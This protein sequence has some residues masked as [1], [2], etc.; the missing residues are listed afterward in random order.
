MFVL[1]LDS[2]MIIYI[3]FLSIVSLAIDNQIVSYAGKKGEDRECIT[4]KEKWGKPLPGRIKIN[5]DA[6]LVTDSNLFPNVDS[7]SAGDWYT[8]SAI[9]RDHI[10]DPICAVTMFV[11]AVSINCAE[12]RAIELGADL[13]IEL[14]YLNVILESDSLNAIR[15]VDPMK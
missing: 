8:V 6:S 4:V 1:L 9:A 12:L 10:G 7:T 5:V 15:R 3:K 11:R 13:A 2:R 14:K